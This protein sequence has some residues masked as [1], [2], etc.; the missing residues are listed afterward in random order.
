MPIPHGLDGS[1]GEI[2][3]KVKEVEGTLGNISKEK[4]ALRKGI[5]KKL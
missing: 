2:K 5:F 1:G 3:E 4:R